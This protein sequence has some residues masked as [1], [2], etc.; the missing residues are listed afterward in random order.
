M[1]NQLELKELLHYDQ[2]LGTFTWLKSYRDIVTGKIAGTNGRNGYID[3]KI[4]GVRYYAHRL[5]WLYVTGQF[6]LDV[7]DHI[8]R[9]KTNNCFANLRDVSRKENTNNQV[10]AQINNATGIRG[11]LPYINGYSAQI[12]VNGKSKHLGV[13]INI[14]DA[15][16]AYLSAKEM[17]APLPKRRD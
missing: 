7:I 13:F 11:V 16:L 4:K 5:A 15:Q 1:I 10:D 3:I 17:Y 14:E 6:P 9:N 12:A 8:D 2:D